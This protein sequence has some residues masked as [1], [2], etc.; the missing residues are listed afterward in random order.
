MVRELFGVEPDAWQDEVLEAFPHCR[1]IAMKAAKGPGKT[2]T[3]AWLGWNY[4]LTRPR[5]KIAATSVTGDNLA[6]GLW[7]EMA[8]WQHRSPLLKAQFV[9]TKT[10]IFAAQH[11]EEW[12][13]SARTYPKSASTE[14]QA[15]A[16]SGLHADYTLFLIDEAGDIPPAV[17]VTAEATLAS[18]KEGH[19]VIAGNTTSTQGMLYDAVVNHRALWQPISI[20]GDPDDPKR[21]PR[22]SREWAQE[23]IDRYGRDHPYV[24]VNVLG[25]FPPSSFNTLLGL[26]DIR[27]AQARSYREN[28]IERHPRILGVDVALYGD[29]ASVI[30]PRQG[31]V[32]FNPERHRNIEPHLGAGRVAS[33]WGDWDADAVFVDNTGGYGASWISHLRL[34]G[35]SPIGVGFAQAPNDPQYLNKRAEIYFLAANWIK[36]GGQLPPA[37]VPG[38]AE[39]AA[40][41]TQ[42]TYSAKKD[43]L[44]LEPKELVKDRIG[45]SPDDA[46]ALALTFSH[47]VAPRVMRPARRGTV[48][49]DYRP[50]T[51]YDQ[52]R[53]G[54][55]AEYRPMGH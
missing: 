31:L 51:S 15:A 27:E 34:M 32:A 1:R 52:Q 55:R 53:G 37:H 21:S 45:Y 42:T 39:L 16:L 29:D 17:L 10:R 48:S 3:L 6:D 50:L 28:D 7:T 38:M 47:P 33:R 14:D 40:A 41:L 49:A 9:W 22:I 2:A 11:P 26:D 8:K 13:M 46:D 20:T 18:G 43:K 19:I 5:P 44:V 54:L 4:L 30:F 36:E 35:R 25:Q 12:W 23:L 24:M